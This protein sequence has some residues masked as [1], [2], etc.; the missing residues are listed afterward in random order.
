[1]TL[2][3]VFVLAAMCTHLAAISLMKR[4]APVA[5]LCL[6]SISNVYRDSEKC[7]FRQ[8]VSEAGTTE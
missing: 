8:W 6:W 5:V 7:P 3:Q 4:S 2:Q 1:M